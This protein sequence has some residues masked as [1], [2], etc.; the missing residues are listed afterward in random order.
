MVK[1]DLEDSVIQLYQGGLSFKSIEK[2]LNGLINSTTA[3]NIIKRNNIPTRT[4]GGI[5]K[6]PIEEIVE[7]YYNQNILVSDIAT[8]YNVNEK[9]I[10]NYLEKNGHKAKSMSEH[11]NPNLIHGYFKN[12]DTERKAYFLGFIIADGSVGLR[13]HSSP[14]IGISVNKRDEY[15]LEEF[16]HEIKSDNKISY[17]AKKDMSTFRIHSQEMF[18]DLSQYGVVPNK[19]FKTYLPMIKNEYMPHLIR[20]IF[21]GDGWI[22]TRVDSGG[23]QRRTLG[24]CGTYDFMEQIREYLCSQLDVYKVKVIQGRT[25]PSIQFSSKRDVMMIAQHMYRDSTVCLK[26]KY[27]KLKMIL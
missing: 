12:I 26:R 22:T 15:L 24:I 27:D 8:K 6:L 2:E 11:Y 16:K 9:T 3:F 18:D 10:Y 4:K 14:V 1:K 19:T 20:G 13:E 21:D 25:I 5:Y 23:H 17:S 7:D